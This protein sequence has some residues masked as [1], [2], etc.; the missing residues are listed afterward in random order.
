M[1]STTVFLVVFTPTSS[2]SGCYVLTN[3]T[4]FTINKNLQSAALHTTLTSAE[5]CPGYASPVGKGGAPG[6]D[7]GGAGLPA[8]IRVDVT[9]SG[10]GV[11]ATSHDKSSFQCLQ[12][13]LDGTFTM[14]TS[15]ASA[16]GTIDVVPGTTFNTPVA[17]TTWVDTQEKVAGTPDPACFPL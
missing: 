17:S 3:P 9:W 4:D 11:V 16:T 7:G 14:R 12:Y 8:S 2:D 5:L 13:N 15:N 1:Q 6:V 10:L